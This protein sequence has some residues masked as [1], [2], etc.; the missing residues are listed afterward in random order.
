MMV[1]FVCKKFC[2]LL[3]LVENEIFC[4]WALF[5]KI[6]CIK[7]QSTQNPALSS[8]MMLFERITHPPQKNAAFLIQALSSPKILLWSSVN[9]P[10]LSVSEPLTPRSPI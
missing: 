6:L 1:F 10:D 5:K 7:T 9:D 4:F 8:I 3:V 2:S